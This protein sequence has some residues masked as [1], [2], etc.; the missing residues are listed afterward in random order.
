MAVAEPMP[1]VK[2]TTTSNAV[3]LALFQDCHA[4]DRNGAM[5]N[6]LADGGVERAFRLP[7]RYSYRHSSKNV[8]QDAGVAPERSLHNLL[9]CSTALRPERRRP[10]PSVRRPYPWLPT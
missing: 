9:G 3:A 10:D 4:C 8:G 1:T 5:A 6:M 2:A 7:C